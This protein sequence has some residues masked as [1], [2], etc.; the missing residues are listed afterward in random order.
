MQIQVEAHMVLDTD[1][2]VSTFTMEM[3]SPAARSCSA[4]NEESGTKESY[5]AIK[6]SDEGGLVLVE[7]M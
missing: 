2:S 4:Q 7:T 6:M 3:R 1:T 5:R